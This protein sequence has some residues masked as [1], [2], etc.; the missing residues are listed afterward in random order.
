MLIKTLDFHFR[1]Q[2]EGF[3]LDVYPRDSSQ[4]LATANLNFPRS[5]LSGSELKQLDFDAK[6]PAGRVDRLREFGRKLYQ[7]ILTPEVERIWLEQKQSNEF[8]VLCIRIAADANELEAIAWETLFDGEEFITAGTKTTISRL[9]LDVQPQAA[10]PAV[11]LPLKMLALVSSPLDLPDNSRLQ[12]EREQEILLEAINDPAGQGRLRADF[13]D[14]AKLEILEGSLETSYQIFHFTG[15][16]IPLENG[17]GLLLEDAQ[18]KSRP[19]SVTEV[20]QSLQRGENSLRLVVL[21]G[22]QTSRTINMAGLRDM[23]RGLLRR[24]I[25]AVIAMQFS[26]S[27]AG[28]LKFAE[29]FYTRIATGR[30]LELAVHAARRAMLLSDDY[31]LQA[32]ALAPVLLTSNGDCLQTTQAEAASTFEAPKIDFSFY[33]PLAQLSHGFYGRRREYRQIR[34]GILQR[35]QRAVIVH[36]IGGIGK[37]A[38]VSHIATRLKKR[39]QGVYAFDCSS[40]TLAPET[41]MIKLHQY[42]APQG[43]M[44]LEQLLYQNLPPDVLANYLAQIL[45]QYSLLLIFDNFESQLGERTDTGFRIA[46]ENLRTFITTL[47]KTTAT[48]S[49]FLFT[50]RY[51]FELDDKRLGSIQ[52]LPLED[53][54]RPEALSLMQKLQ[55]L[56]AASHTEK[57]EALKT[58]GGHPYALVTLDRYCGHQPLSRALAEA[59]NIHAELR[60]FLAIELNYAQLSNQSRE[61]LNHLA[62]FRQS[63]PYKAAEWVIGQKVAHEPEL[64]E[65]LLAKVRDGWPKQWEGHFDEANIL[66]I[67]KESLPDRRQAEDL[68]RPIKE[69]IEWGLLTPTQED[70]QLKELSVHALVREFC[71]DK[72]LGETWRDCLRDA[73]AFYTNLTKLS[74]GENKTQAEI[75]T[76]VEAF[77][78][79]MEAGDFNDAA[80]LLFGADELLIR[81]GFGQY[82]EGQYPRLADKLDANGTATLLHRLGNLVFIRDEHEKALEYY[83][84]SLKIYEELGSRRFMAYPLAQIGSIHYKRREYDKAMENYEQALG[85]SEEFRDYSSVCATL[86][87]IGMIHEERHEFE[88]AEEYYSRSMKI[89]G[90]TND[91]ANFATSLRQAGVLMHKS[92]FDNGKALDFY[93]QSLEI[94]EELNDRAGIATTLTMIGDVYLEMSQYEKASEYYFHSLRIREELGSRLDI[95]ALLQQIATIHDKQGAHEKALEY[96]ERSLNIREELVDRA[97]IATSLHRIAMIQESLGNVGK[98]L[99]YYN[100]SLKISEELDDPKGIAT[101]LMQ[102]GLIYHRQDKYDEAWDCYNRSIRISEERD[103]PVSLAHALNVRGM[104]FVSLERPQEAFDDLLSSWKK[105]T[106]L[107]SPDAEGPMD[108]LKLLRAEWGERNF[109]AEWRKATGERVPERLKK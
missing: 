72:Q 94:F 14:E 97:G 66:R 7:Q 90:Q 54:S 63:V 29:A 38:L 19:T 57:L 6:D 36:G 51:L 9:P 101:P 17:G 1:K 109:D 55:H 46:D 2:N 79:L 56:A 23:A 71:C 27:D 67:I 99:E 34:D 16:G 3:Q 40:G 65:R 96:S 103:L 26:I 39:F 44:A 12:M 84:R 52:S 68:I 78:L 69:L 28:G 62:A 37:T 41:V 88:K 53:L 81:W 85:V 25:P 11:T 91:R 82:L 32:D 33:L 48:A 102:I 86:H 83:N 30:T 60:E 89:A 31:Y 58:F 80:M 35:N 42:F 104:L 50:S 87:Q 77:E 100:R 24:K 21:S 59:K 4:L 43:V 49:H 76:D 13:E 70:G 20:L 8:L 47:I 93:H 15:H 92:G 5:F 95:A 108:M 107:E 64:L 61:L 73:A 74:T 18:G 22:C 105:F 106:D 10:L 98:A 75:W 45:S